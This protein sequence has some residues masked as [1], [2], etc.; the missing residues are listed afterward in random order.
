MSGRTEKE[1]RS[2]SRCHL[3]VGTSGYSYTE[4]VDAGFYPPDTPSG[5]MLSLYA[6]CFQITELNYTW[7]QMPQAEAVERQRQQVSS[8]FVFAAKLTRTLTHEIDPHNWPRDADRYREGVAPLM[9]SGQ[10]MAVLI[11][12][13]PTFNRSPSNRKHL[14]HLLDALAG[15]PL[16]I[17]FRHRSWV[18]ERVFSELERRQVTLV[19]V[20]APALPG[21]YPALDVVTNPDLFYVRFHGRNAKGWRSGNM[22]QQFD[23]HYADDE[24]HEWVEK[25]IEPMSRHAHRGVLFFNNHVRGQAPANAQRMRALLMERG[26]LSM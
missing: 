12:L 3:L 19:G 26:L 22:H 13:P 16:A 10:L 2:S 20:D 6:R 4:W 18:H 9:Q 23:Y 15:L 24:L 7:Y 8:Q 11:Q 17:E 5:R 21:L 1:P 25:R 14:A